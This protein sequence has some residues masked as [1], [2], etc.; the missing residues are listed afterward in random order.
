MR[1]LTDEEEMDVAIELQAYCVI[2]AVRDN[3]SL[4]NFDCF[5]HSRVCWSDEHFATYTV[6]PMVANAK[7]VSAFFHPGKL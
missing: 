6:R 3:F 5:E 1:R 2:I 7:M 4:Q